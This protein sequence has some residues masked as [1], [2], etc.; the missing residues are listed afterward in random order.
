MPDPHYPTI[1][2]A[3]LEQLIEQAE[4]YQD[5]VKV[6]ST[7]LYVLQGTSS[8]KKRTV[9]VR[10]FADGQVGFENATGIAIRLNFMG[11]LLHWLETNRD[12]KDGAY[13]VR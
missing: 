2:A 12:W 1:D 6:G 11:A 8:I 5:K 13:V 7:T 9:L 3:F 10:T 4:K